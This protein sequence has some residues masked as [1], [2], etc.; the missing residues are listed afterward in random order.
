MIMGDASSDEELL[1]NARKGNA[2]AFK[3]LV[4]RYEG[5]V[6]G[7]IK[8]MLGDTPQAVDVGQEVFIRFYESLENFKGQSAL[9][10]YLIRIAIN[11]S[12]NELK[13][14]KRRDTLFRPLEWGHHVKEDEPTKDTYE[15]LYRAIDNLDPDFKLVVTLRMIEGYSTDETAK[16]LNIPLGTVLS[17]LARAQRKLKEALSKQN[18]S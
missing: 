18:V 16:L 10:T 3:T 7:V 1:S 13:R 4:E 2:G 12:L 14:M 17:R 8:S 9:G 15:Q 5:K 11:L 6:A